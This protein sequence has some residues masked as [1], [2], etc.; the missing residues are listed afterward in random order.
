MILFDLAAPFYSHK[1]FLFDILHFSQK[2]KKLSCVS[3][4]YIYIYIYMY[5]NH[6][7]N[8][9]TKGD[10][11]SDKQTVERLARWFILSMTLL[12]FKL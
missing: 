8:L 9:H 11:I 10:Y 6:S 7:R 4:I 12:E 5:M 1:L 2:C 3:Y